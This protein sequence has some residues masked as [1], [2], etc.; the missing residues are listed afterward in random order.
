ME[1]MIGFV[2]YHLLHGDSIPYTEALFDE[3]FGTPPPGTWADA[4]VAASNA[5]AAAGNYGIAPVDTILSSLAPPGHEGDASVRIRA[6]VQY[7]RPDG[8]TYWRTMDR[9]QPTTWNVGQ[10]LADLFSAAEVT[11]D[12]YEVTVG[13]IEVVPP[14]F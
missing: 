14:L 2:I 10:S 11:A 3:R 13:A 12:N 9:D 1:Q 6:I 8:T 7:V 4:L 5:I